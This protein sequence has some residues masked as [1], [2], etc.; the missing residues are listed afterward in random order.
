MFLESDIWF[1]V[2]LVTSTCTLLVF[3]N[4]GYD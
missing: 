1:V 4:A 2:F 3:A